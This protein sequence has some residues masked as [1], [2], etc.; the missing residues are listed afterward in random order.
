M[1]LSRLRCTLTRQRDEFG[2]R[3][4]HVFLGCRRKP[5]PPGSCCEPVAQNYLMLAAFVL[6]LQ[7]GL[8]VSLCGLV[9]WRQQA[10]CMSAFGDWTPSLL[11]SVHRSRREW[12]GLTEL[13]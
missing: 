11:F 12:W 4:L 10:F 13:G 3:L 5:A 8:Q 6:G 9:N 2:L 1:S 7:A